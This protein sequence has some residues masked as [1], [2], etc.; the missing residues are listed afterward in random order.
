[1]RR[2]VRCHPHLRSS[3]KA[4][5]FYLLS[6]AGEIL[7]E[8]VLVFPEKH[9]ERQEQEREHSFGPLAGKPV[10]VAVLSL[11]GPQ[12]LGGRSTWKGHSPPPSCPSTCSCDKP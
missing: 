4:L 5:R 12:P 3:A 8:S 10:L 9:G 7:T 6:M 2:W 11:W 1:M